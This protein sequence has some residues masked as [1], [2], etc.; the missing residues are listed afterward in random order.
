MYAH[1]KLECAVR[2]RKKEKV[3]FFYSEIKSLNDLK[4]S[5]FMYYFFGRRKI[6]VQLLVKVYAVKK[7]LW[8]VYHKIEGRI[9]RHDAIY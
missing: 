9:F 7:M 6:T 1:I 4:L 5:D 2:Y 8:C 3:S